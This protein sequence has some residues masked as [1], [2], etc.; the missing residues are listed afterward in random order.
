MGIEGIESRR[1]VEHGEVILVLPGRVEHEAGVDVRAQPRHLEGQESP[2]LIGRE[3]GSARAEA[4]KPPSGLGREME[5]GGRADRCLA[6]E[7]DA[8]KADLRGEDGGEQGGHDGAPRPTWRGSGEPAGG[9]R[10][11]PPTGGVRCERDCSDGGQHPVEQDHV[12]IRHQRQRREPEQHE[13]VRR[14]QARANQQHGRPQRRQHPPEVARHLRRR[15]REHEGG[16]V[17]RDGRAEHVARRGLDAR[18]QARGQPNGVETVGRRERG[19]QA[20]RERDPQSRERAACRRRSAWAS[21]RDHIAQQ[22][23]A[24]SGPG[25][26]ERVPGSSPKSPAARGART[27]RVSPAPTYPGDA[28]R[29]RRGRSLRGSNVATMGRSGRRCLARNNNPSSAAA[30][31]SRAAGPPARSA[32]RVPSMAPAATR[33]ALAAASP[34]NPNARWM[35]ATAT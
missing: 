8:G 26:A 13:R 29:G 28:V 32:V 35:S 7:R 10:G 12:S 30:Q 1:L 22:V 6:G 23:G 4:G 5:R 18:E 3:H 16:D 9:A 14:D 27:R 25:R 19:E 17:L 31:R 11:G 21:R 20:A 2:V 24:R 15:S 34:P 33:T